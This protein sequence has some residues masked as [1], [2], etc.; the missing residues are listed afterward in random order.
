LDFRFSIF[1][2]GLIRGRHDR[3]WPAVPRTPGR[4]IQNPKSPESKIQMNRPL[5]SRTPR[6]QRVCN[7]VFPPFALAV[8]VAAATAF[9]VTDP[10]FSKIRR[11]DSRLHQT[12]SDRI[13]HICRGGAV[14]SLL[15]TTSCSRAASRRPTRYLVFKEPHN[16]GFRTFDFGFP[17][18][19]LAFGSE[20]QARRG[21]AG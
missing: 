6:A 9:A 16:F 12:Q 5:R 19:P 8:L 1:D 10:A 11:P 2:C 4:R 15:S 21:E 7:Q 14:Y 13:L 20:A 3:K 17:P 18:L